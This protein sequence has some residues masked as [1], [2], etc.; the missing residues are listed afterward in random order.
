MSDSNIRYY[1]GTEYY[2]MGQKGTFRSQQY[3]YQSQNFNIQFKQKTKFNQ[4]EF[5]GQKGRL[6]GLFQHSTERQKGIE[7]EKNQRMK[8]QRSCFKIQTRKNTKGKNRGNG[9]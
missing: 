3:N 6:K 7:Y 4:R 9:K 2:E 1:D 5:S 8:N